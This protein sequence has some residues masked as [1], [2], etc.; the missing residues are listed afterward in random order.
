VVEVEHAV[1]DVEAI[2]VDLTVVMEEAEVVGEVGLERSERLGVE[3][4]S[5]G[6]S[7]RSRRTSLGTSLSRSRR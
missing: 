3:P 1:V 7:N 6:R 5:R 4:C 2:T